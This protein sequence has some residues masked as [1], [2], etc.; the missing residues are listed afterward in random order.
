MSKQPIGRKSKHYPSW[1]ARDYWLVA[2]VLRSIEAERPSKKV[3]VAAF[4]EELQH[5]NPAFNPSMFEKACFTT[6]EN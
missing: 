2:D 5:T 4:I 3:V 6:K 1:T